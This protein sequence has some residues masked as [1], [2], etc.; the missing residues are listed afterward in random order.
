MQDLCDHPESSSLRQL[1]VCLSSEGYP[2]CHSPRC[3]ECPYSIESY[4]SQHTAHGFVLKDTWK[5]HDIEYVAGKGKEIMTDRNV[6][7][8]S[9][10]VLAMTIVQNLMCIGGAL[11]PIDILTQALP[12]IAAAQKLAQTNPAKKRVA[13]RS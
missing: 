4:Q 2:C 5:Q 6:A 3:R 1:L 9:A 8:S 10:L 7:I 13:G 12:L 11:M